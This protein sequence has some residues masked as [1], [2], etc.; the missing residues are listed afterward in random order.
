[1]S[2]PLCS[3]DTESLGVYKCLDDS[4][5][6]VMVCKNCLSLFRDPTPSAEQ[7]DSYYA[8]RGYRPTKRLLRRR[9]R[10]TRGQARWITAVLPGLGLNEDSSILDLGAGIGGL[11]YSLRK[12]GFSDV[13]SVEGREAAID[14]AGE[15][16]GVNLRPGWVFDA[17]R[18]SESPQLICISHVLEHVADPVEIVDY[19]KSAFPGSLLFIEVPDG[20]L[21]VHRAGRET[22]WN[23]WLEQHLWSYTPT[24][25]SAMLEAN[26]LELLRLEQGTSYHGYGAVRRAELELAGDLLLAARHASMSVRRT[27]PLLAR[28]AFVGMPVQL[29]KRVVSRMPFYSKPDAPYFVRCVSRLP[30]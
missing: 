8:T 21:D 11:E 19:L 2:C 18:Y 30:R 12:R 1:M 25:L 24:G 28:M 22:V 17:H 10:K 7:L 5:A 3:G 13:V 23:L 27:L 16:L 15:V 26:G 14:F 4:T 6:S 20:S 29:Y 9:L